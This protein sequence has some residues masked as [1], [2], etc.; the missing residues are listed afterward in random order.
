MYSEKFLVGSVVLKL[1][2]VDFLNRW[3]PVPEFFQMDACHCSW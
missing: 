3:P 1:N 2:L